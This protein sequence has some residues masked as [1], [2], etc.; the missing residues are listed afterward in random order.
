VLG[1]VTPAQADAL[2]R[3]ALS[4]EQLVVLVNTVLL[5]AYRDLPPATGDEPG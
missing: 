2:A 4:K 3:I 5:R 1:P